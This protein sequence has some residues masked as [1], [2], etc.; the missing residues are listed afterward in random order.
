MDEKTGTVIREGVESIINPLDLYAIESA[1]LLGEQRGWET[2]ALSMGPPKA[3]EAL[4]EAIAMG[5]GSAVLL[6]DK[7]FAGSD[8][9]ATAHVL[10]EAI[11]KFGDYSLVVCGER[12]TDG[13]TGQVG[14][15]IAAYLG[16]PVVSYV[17]NIVSA[18]AATCVATRLVEDGCERVEMTLPGVIT[19]VKEV[20][21]PRLPTLRG[22]QKA[23]KAQIPVWGLSD[24]AL[25]PRMVGL[26]GSPTR[27]GKIFRPKIARECEKLPATDEERMSAAVD[28][29]CLFLREKSL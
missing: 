10:G 9:W 17:N 15:G 6:S 22:K 25:D 2:I 18:D 7:A 21:D 23:R 5:I 1:I 28:R 16:L 3:V 20:S 12:A 14:P 4:K 27:V 29:V 26:N 24:L 13:D 19:V 11:K 8:T